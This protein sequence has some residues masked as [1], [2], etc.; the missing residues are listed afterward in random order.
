MQLSGQSSKFSHAGQFVQ[1]DM[2]VD[3]FD[4]RL[5]VLT[6]VI[7]RVVGFL[8]QARAALQQLTFFAYMCLASAPLS[9]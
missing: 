5:L 3:V 6:Y 9:G 2:N 1:E 4:V 8:C 7:A